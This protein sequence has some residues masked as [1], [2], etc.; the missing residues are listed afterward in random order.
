MWCA[1]AARDSNFKS[2]MPTDPDSPARAALSG[3][4]AAGT[5]HGRR[6]SLAGS[7]AREASDSPCPIMALRRMIT[8]LW[9]EAAARRAR[10]TPSHLKFKSRLSPTRRWTRTA[11]SAA[12]A[13]GPL[14]DGHCDA[15][16]MGVL[17][18]VSDL[19]DSY[20]TGRRL[21]GSHSGRRRP[22]SPGCHGGRSVPPTEV[23]QF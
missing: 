19:Q 8:K 13:P 16:P 17:R 4:V 6:D 23:G 3:T 10:R 18:T 15:L 12:A 9:H 21:P 7:P 5:G 11:R 22:Q 20:V 2:L 14:S 1:K